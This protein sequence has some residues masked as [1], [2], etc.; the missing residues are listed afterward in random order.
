MMKNAIFKVMLAVV[1]LVGAL[2]ASAQDAGNDRI[3]RAQLLLEKLQ[4]AD[5]DSVYEHMDD[6]MKAG[7]QPAQLKSM[8]QM[9]VMQM[10]EYGGAE[11]WQYVRAINMDIVTARLSFRAMDLTYS[12]TYDGQ[13]RLAG[14]FF[15]P[16]PAKTTADEDADASCDFTEKS[17]TVVTDGF[18]LGATLTLP[19]GVD[20]PPCVILVHGSGPND[21]DETIMQNK[22]FRDIAEGL[23]ACGVASLRYDK[24]TY[25]CAEAMGKFAGEID[26]DFEVV[27]DVLSAYRLL[28]GSGSLVDTSRI[29]VVGHSLGG[30]LVPRILSRERGLRGGV[31]MSANATRLDSVMLYQIGYL[32]AM[33]PGAVSAEA[34]ALVRSVENISRYGTDGFDCS[35]PAPAG[36]T[37]HYWQDILSYNQVE[38]AVA[39]AQPLLVLGCKGD[40]QVPPAEMEKWRKAL[41]AKGNVSFKEYDG[42]SHIYMEAGEKP[43]PADYMKKSHVPQYV[44]EDIA[45]FVRNN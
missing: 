36:T 21:R 34:E 3:V 8:W 45:E 29:F 23:A 9:L 38:A 12:C 40:Y 25:A 26:L 27:D 20:N 16:A 22:P 2:P 28:C 37:M 19:R 33:Q 31:M 35:I 39:V 17:M 18:E 14:L 10:G 7:I 6:K 44:M 4:Q 1:L 15:T 32:S 11:D 13:G 5:T 30:M 24:R 41:G 43:S 42:L